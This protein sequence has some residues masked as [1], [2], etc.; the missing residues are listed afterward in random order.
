M[1]KSSSGDLKTN[2]VRLLDQAQIR[3]NC[4]HTKWMR[5]I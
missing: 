2:A 3:L 4:G 1:A 5:A